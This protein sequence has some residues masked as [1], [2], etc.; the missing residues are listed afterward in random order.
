MKEESSVTPTIPEEPKHM[1]IEEPTEVQESIVEP[2]L[3]KRPKS[4]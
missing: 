4:V 3:P 2:E 1:E